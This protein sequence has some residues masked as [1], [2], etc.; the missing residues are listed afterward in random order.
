MAGMSIKRIINILV[1]NLAVFLVLIFSVEGISRVIIPE[2]EIKAIFNDQELRVRGRAF[3]ELH[4]TRGFALKPNFTNDLYSINKD[5]FRGEDF[6]TDLN[7]RLRI[8]TLGESTTF[9]WGVK[10]QETIP[11]YLM[12]DFSSE[13]Q[14]VYVI[15]GGIPSYTS[16]QVLEY[17]RQILE[18]KRI[19][20][21]IILIN[22]LWND[23]W[24]STITNWH[25]DILIFQKPPE[26]MTYLVN[27]SRFI[28][29]MIMGFN[30]KSELV[31]I[32]NEASLIQYGKNIEEMINLCRENNI[33]LL[34]VEPPFDS[35][36]MPEEGLNEFH[37]RYTKDFFIKISE[38]YMEKMYD[39]A[40]KYKVS[41]IKH[42]LGLKN[43]HQKSL[44]L[45]P[46][47]PTPEGNAMIAEDIYN[48]M[49]EKLPAGSNQR[50]QESSATQS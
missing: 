14:D 36:H 31:N 18:E 44:F 30:N 32:P 23:I 43:L 13:R 39:V 29:G 22:I 11:A 34:L 1:V 40:E 6:P 38:K 28:R 15:N 33:G 48:H 49:A 26:W 4:E 27:H 9:G 25:P 3:V 47:H 42:R 17:L 12:N 37:V 50:V 7:N 8:L 45:D 5:G 24:Y 35:D 21:D 2:S 16:S 20:P 41:V 19:K 46:L 10:D